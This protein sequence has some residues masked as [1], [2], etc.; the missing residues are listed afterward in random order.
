MKHSLFIKKL[1]ALF[2]ALLL[3]AMQAAALAETAAQAD[4][5]ALV[6]GDILHVTFTVTGSNLAAA[7]GTFAYDTSLL[8]FSDDESGGGV[9]DGLFA[10][11]SAQKDGSSTL[12]VRVG[13]KARAAGEAKVTFTLESLLDYAGKALDGGSAEVTVTIAAGPEQTPEPPVD[14]SDPALTLK[15][16]NVEGA[17][18]DMYIWRSIDNVTI[19][20]RYQE[21]DVEYHGTA[22]RGATV[23]D[24][25]APALYYLSD[26]AGKNGGYYIYDA[27]GDS[28]YRYRTVSTVSK[29][30][31]LLKPGAGVTVPEGFTETTLEIDGTSTQAWKSA[32]GL[33]L[34]YARNPSGET[35]FYYYAPEDEAFQRYSVRPAQPVTP[36]AGDAA[37][38]GPNVDASIP[39]GGEAG[40]PKTNNTAFI[41]AVAAAVLFLVL[42]AA[43]VAYF[44]IKEKK[45][46]ARAAER[47][48]A[49]AAAAAQQ[50]K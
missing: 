3:M 41:I 21:A 44:T 39:D 13:F 5:E 8:A 22:V 36:E 27:A 42:F 23:A 20:S 29:A 40:E 1:T 48:A 10:V 14:Y 2:A 17:E 12:T 6:E 38:D 33:Y 4:S 28:F 37:G 11:Y 7:Q 9:T 18:G 49:R 35:G 19:P 43:S 30:Y 50:R 16:E 45:R 46:K 31:I 15:A 32:D 34:L 25:D 24:S 26:A 47:R